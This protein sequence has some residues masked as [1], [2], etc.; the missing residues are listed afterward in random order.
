VILNTD[1]FSSDEHPR[2]GAFDLLDLTVLSAEHVCSE[3]LSAFVFSELNRSDSTD[4]T[5]DNM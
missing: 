5:A 3:S 4:D 1:A 2:D